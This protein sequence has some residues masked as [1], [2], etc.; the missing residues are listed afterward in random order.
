MCELLLLAKALTIAIG[1]DDVLWPDPQQHPDKCGLV[2]LL[3]ST[4]SAALL[5]VAQFALAT[6]VVQR[7]VGI[8]WMKLWKMKTDK[9]VIASVFWSN[10]VRC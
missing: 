9:A 6:T 4:G 10:Q 5:M 1:A 7:Y 3:T 2:L 8:P